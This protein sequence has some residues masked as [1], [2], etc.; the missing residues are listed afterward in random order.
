M[1]R[2]L[3]STNKISLMH[4]LSGRVTAHFLLYID[5]LIKNDIPKAFTMGFLKVASRLSGV[6]LVATFRLLLLKYTRILIASPAGRPSQKCHG[7]VRIFS[8]DGEW[9]STPLFHQ[10]KDL[11][12]CVFLMRTVFYFRFQ[13]FVLGVLTKGPKIWSNFWWK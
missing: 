12:I 5:I 3:N 10:S 13:F 8:R 9:V 4:D 7:L 1:S 6:L 2:K 11:A